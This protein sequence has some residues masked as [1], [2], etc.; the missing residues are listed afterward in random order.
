MWLQFRQP[1]LVLGTLGTAQ[2]NIHR[3]RI[4]A[5]SRHPGSPLHA[6]QLSRSPK[7]ALVPATTK[8]FRVGLRHW[9]IL[10][11]PASYRR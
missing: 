8:P 7:S 9:M 4:T 10:I 3:A 5:P 11:E 2:L 1:A 6:Q